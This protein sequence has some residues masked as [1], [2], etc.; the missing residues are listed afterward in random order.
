MSCARFMSLGLRSISQI[1]VEA[2]NIVLNKLI[3]FLNC[4]VVTSILG[5]ANYNQVSRSKAKV[6]I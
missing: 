3:F 4:L 1:K 2:Q 5:V 6:T